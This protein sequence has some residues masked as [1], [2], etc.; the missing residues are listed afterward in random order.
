MLKT[1]RLTP[2]QLSQVCF[3]VTAGICNYTFV[4]H[5]GLGLGVASV[6]DTSLWALTGSGVTEA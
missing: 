2:I 1:C 3:T 6:M 5:M 4:S